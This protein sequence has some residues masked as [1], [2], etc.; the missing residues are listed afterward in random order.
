MSDIAIR[1]EKLGKQYRIG[2][3]V[4]YQTLRDSMTEML[5][6]PFRRLRRSAREN[7]N[8]EEEHIWAVKDVLLR[9]PPW[10]SGLVSSAAT[11]RANPPC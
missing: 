2:R 4:H 5:S 1:V 6:S 8:A 3:R 10:R 7:R 9:N 11:A